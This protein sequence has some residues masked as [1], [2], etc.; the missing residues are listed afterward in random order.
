M[1][2]GGPHGIVANMINFGIVVSKFKL[3]LHYNI[4]FLVN[5]FVKGMD[6]CYSPYPTLL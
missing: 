4:L 1:C 2:G 6:P 5:T 3:Q